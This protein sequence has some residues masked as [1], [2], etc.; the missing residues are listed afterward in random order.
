M[1]VECG[2]FTDRIVVRFLLFP[3][4]CFL[5]LL[6]FIEQRGELVALVGST[7]IS[8]GP[9]VHFEISKDGR[10]YNPAWV[11]DGMDADGV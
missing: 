7:G 11:L 10:Y 3:S 5:L 4:G 1:I 6:R 8:T 2:L 9:H